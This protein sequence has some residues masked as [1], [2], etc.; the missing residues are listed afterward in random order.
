MFALDP[1]VDLLLC[2][3]Y[4]DGG[5]RLALVTWGGEG[6]G[7]DVRV[8]SA[9]GGGHG[10]ALVEE[11]E[12]HAR[13][14]ARVAGV[15]VEVCTLDDTAICV[16]AHVLTVCAC[17]RAGTVRARVA[18][19]E[20]DGEAGAVAQG[21]DVAVV[22]FHVAAVEELV[23]GGGELVCVAGGVLCGACW[24]KAVFD[25]VPRVHAFVFL[26]GVSCLFAFAPMWLRVFFARFPARHDTMG[27]TAA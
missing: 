16:C 26:S 3:C 18:V 17:A 15:S 11:D 6:A 2:E 23:E 21:D 10:F 25:V 5:E 4:A 19:C 14:G 12:R 13:D 27:V 1:R 7:G 22:A 8:G 24:S 20:G 9:D